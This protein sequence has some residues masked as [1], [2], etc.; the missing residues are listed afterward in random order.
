MLYSTSPIVNTL[1]FLSAKCLSAKC[2]SI[3][4]LGTVKMG[5]LFLPS[6]HPLPRQRHWQLFNCT[7]I[8]KKDPNA[9]TS[10]KD[11]IPR[12]KNDNIFCDEIKTIHLLY[13]N[14]TVMSFI[15][16]ICFS[17]NVV[18]LTLCAKCRQEKCNIYIYIYVCVRVRACVCLRVCVCACVCACVCVCVCVCVWMTYDWSRYK[19]LTR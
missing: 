13:D 5:L 8:E 16:F 17:L 4:R 10:L 3:E 18:L 6:V 12:F 15:C 14:V 9:S 1:T 19:L 11:K 7:A 2:Y